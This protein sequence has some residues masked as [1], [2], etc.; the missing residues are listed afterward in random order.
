[1]LMRRKQRLS[2]ESSCEVEILSHDDSS[3]DES[4]DHT[5]SSVDGDYEFSQH[6]RNDRE[7]THRKGHGD[8]RSRLNVRRT[9]R[10][11]E[12]SRSG[13]ES[14]GRERNRHEKW[15]EKQKLKIEFNAIDDSD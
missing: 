1:M 13:Y 11:Y 5:S 15:S 6:H 3:E 10:N 9:D 7:T 8:L 12:R 14:R 2:R 4:S